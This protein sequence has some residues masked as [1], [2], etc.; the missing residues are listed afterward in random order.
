MIR[1]FQA[2]WTWIERAGLVVGL[3]LAT[4]MIVPVSSHVTDDTYTHLQYARH[5]A[6]GKGLVFNP[7]ERV[8]GCTSPLWVTLVADGIAL[9]FEGLA[10]AR[11]LGI[12][13]TLASVALMLQ[14]LRRTLKRPELRALGTV[15]WAG[16]AW[17]IEWSASGLETPLAVAL[18]L[19]GFVAF[20][21]GKAWG[22]RPVRTGA[23]WGMAAL[24]RPEGVFLV[25]LWSAT[26]IIDAQN[27][28]GLRRLVFGLLPV[29]AI[30][31]GWLLFVRF[32]TG[33]FWP[34]ELAREAIMGPALTPL[35]SATRQLRIAFESDGAFLV[36]LPVAL[37][38]GMRHRTD[39][40]RS[41]Q[42]ALPALWLFALPIL[43]AG[44]GTPVT[45]RHLLLVLPVIGWWTWQ[46]AERWWLGGG[47]ERGA[48]VALGLGLAL[49]AV[50]LAQNVA[51][52]RST[53]VPRVLASSRAL[54]LG[55]VRW[56]RWLGMHAPEDATVVT[57]EAGALGYHSRRRVIDLRGRLSPEMIP[58]LERESSAEAA[59]RLDFPARGRATYLVDRSAH[60]YDLEKRSPYGT[61]LI[62]LDRAL[63]PIDEDHTEAPAVY[64]LYRL[65]S[66]LCD[67][68]R[69]SR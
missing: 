46:A 52:Y 37:L 6:E 35:A 62:P 30:Y 10:V 36:L 1:A 48:R 2:P 12:A 13:A 4:A 57:P 21:E 65:D 68:L 29:A 16:N 19:A 43:Y 66:P 54:D 41:A 9:G 32:Y 44:R 5:L 18:V 56:G 3:A 14:L 61:C 15:A 69:V 22:S 60:A 26:L 55:L 27:R 24:T 67:S 49:T 31:G 20:T 33:S 45:S 47:E 39:R 59:E 42:G 53:V 11:M 25:T 40:G 23:L 58:I 28:A 34:H 38:A 17:M 63:A 64:S 51:L 50:V 8:Y 7:G